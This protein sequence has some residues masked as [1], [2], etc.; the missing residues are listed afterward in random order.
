MRSK[1]TPWET[2]VK[3]HLVLA[4]TAIVSV[5]GIAHGAIY[6]SDLL[7]SQENACV[8]TYNYCRTNGGTNCVAT[9]DDCLQNAQEMYQTCVKNSHGCPVGRCPSST[10]TSGFD[11]NFN[12]TPVDKATKTQLKLVR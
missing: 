12:L 7:A 2:L 8:T 1:F 6:C 9:Y 11:T 10:D 3:I 5:T 4:V